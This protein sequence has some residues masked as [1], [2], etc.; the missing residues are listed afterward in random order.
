M[1]KFKK[2]HKQ[3]TSLVLSA[4]MIFSLVPG[5]VGAKAETRVEKQVN[6]TAER[7]TNKKSVSKTALKT[8][9][10][11]LRHRSLQNCMRRG[12]FLVQQRGLH[13][14]L[15]QQPITCYSPVRIRWYPE[16]LLH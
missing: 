4:A 11:V 7:D 6:Q 12:G 13:L 14:T 8:I 3:L 15:K 1:E 2:R 9:S 16:R 5:T 10:A